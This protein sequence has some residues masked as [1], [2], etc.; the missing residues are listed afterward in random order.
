MSH[1]KSS[2][3]G[4]DWTKLLADPDLARNVG[5]LLQVYR[6]A[7]PERRE[8]ALLATM[9]EIKKAADTAPLP[10]RTPTESSEKLQT[11]AVNPPPF[12]PDI[13]G[14]NW[15]DNRRRHPR[16][17]CFVAVELRVDDSD[18]PIW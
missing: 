2:A 11:L 14:A 4:T 7:P 1:S 6:D 12:E 15:G 9:R 13:F 10:T 3:T 5:K 18:A 17:N 8:A 16:I